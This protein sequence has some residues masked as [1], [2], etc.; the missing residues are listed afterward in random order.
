MDITISRFAIITK[1]SLTKLSLFFFLLAQSFITQAANGPDVDELSESLNSSW[2]TLLKT[3]N[4]NLP[5][6]Q[7]ALCIQAHHGKTITVQ[8]FKQ[9]VNALI[10]FETFTTANVSGPVVTQQSGFLIGPFDG[11]GYKIINEQQS[12]GHHRNRQVTD[13]G[14]KVSAHATSGQGIAPQGIALNKGKHWLDG[15]N[16]PWIYHWSALARANE[17]LK[18]LKHHLEKQYR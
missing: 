1:P 6:P 16:E 4:C 3:T 8:L 13:N 10:L 7:D 9:P 14:L 11:Y 12:Q 17:S 2:Q 15:K 18:E 5:T